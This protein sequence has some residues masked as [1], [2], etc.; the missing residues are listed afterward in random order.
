MPR[1]FA[2]GLVERGDL[3]TVAVEPAGPPPAGSGEVVALG[4]GPLAL[5]RREAQ[6]PAGTTLD[7]DRE[8]ACH[9]DRFTPSWP[10]DPDAAALTTA[11]GSWTGAQLA[12]LARA[13]RVPG[14]ALLLT[15]PLTTL[16]AVL[17]GLLVPLAT[18]VTA[19]LCRHVDNLRL[20]WR[21]EQEEVVLGVMSDTPGT[22]RWVPDLVRAPR[23]V[24]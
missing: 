22:P 10:A 16:V 12:T 17:G 20:P 21:V 1:L 13:Q 4:L 15:E 19:V 6:P 7:Y 2:A 24:T 11:D 18:D 3:V 8:V 14:R 5:P 9:G 23:N